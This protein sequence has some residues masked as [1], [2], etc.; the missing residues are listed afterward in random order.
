MLQSLTNWA[1]SSFLLVRL[2]E[3][4]LDSGEALDKQQAPQKM[5]RS[6][7]NDLDSGINHSRTCIFGRMGPR[8][9]W[10][11]LVRFGDSHWLLCYWDGPVSRQFCVSELWTNYINAEATFGWICAGCRMHDDLMN[12]IRV[13]ESQIEQLETSINCKIEAGVF[14]IIKK[15]GKALKRENQI[16]AK[17]ESIKKKLKLIIDNFSTTTS[18]LHTF[19]ETWNTIWKEIVALDNIKHPPPVPQ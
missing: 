14:E 9:A 6:E 5:H 1:I 19:E 13:L 3:S 17:E 18:N 4:E 10:L 2:L 16:R 7:W 8:G 11:C 12:K 15:A